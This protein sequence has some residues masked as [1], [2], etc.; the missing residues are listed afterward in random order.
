[1]FGDRGHFDA[2]TA[3]STPI[4]INL[5]H[6]RRAGNKPVIRNLVLEPTATVQQHCSS[7]EGGDGRRG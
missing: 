6:A 5:L 2:S 1:M 4:R 3:R 7:E